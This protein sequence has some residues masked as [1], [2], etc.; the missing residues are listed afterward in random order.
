VKPVLVVLAAGASARLGRC[1]ALV[2]LAGRSPLERLLAAGAC[3]DGHPP[4]VVT[5]ADHDAIARAVPAVCELLHNPRWAEGRSGGILLAHRRL[6]DRALCLAPVDV[7]LVP[8]PVFEA[9]ARK[10]EELGAPPSGW[11]SP[12][13]EAP[14]RPG[15]GRH[16]HPVVLGPAL[17]DSLEGLPPTASLR[18]LRG[19]ARPLAQVAVEQV[20]ILDD[21][22]LPEDLRRLRQRLGRA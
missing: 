21:L 17:L 10:W 6:P 3:L 4:L 13:L 5:G 22:D 14:G 11:L 15:D 7:P 2:D 12:R 20:A 19:R 18:E 9:L 16:G 8:A 1:K